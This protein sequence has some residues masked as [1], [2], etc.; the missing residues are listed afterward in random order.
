MEKEK[1]SQAK[2]QRKMRIEVY[3]KEK[4]GEILKAEK[5]YRLKLKL[6]KTESH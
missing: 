2:K 3:N 5:E 1:I 4:I 6:S